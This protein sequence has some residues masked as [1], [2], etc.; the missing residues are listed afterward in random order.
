MAILRNPIYAGAYAYNRWGDE[1][2]DPEEPSAGGRILIRETH[3]GYISWQQYLQ[4]G[5][6]LVRNR[7]PPGMRPTRPRGGIGRW[8]RRIGWWPAPWSGREKR[9]SEARIGVSCGCRG[10]PS[11]KKALITK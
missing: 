8:S 10:G 3:P 7:R 9:Y 5:S 6:R 4:N 2:V 1:A 11:Q